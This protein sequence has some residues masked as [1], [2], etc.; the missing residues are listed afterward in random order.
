MAEE[1]P[2]HELSDAKEQP[3]TYL[4]AEPVV[5]EQANKRLWV[6]ISLPRASVWGYISKFICHFKAL[7][8]K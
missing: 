8:V 5:T 2:V 6:Y 7:G 1:T 4:R 3:T